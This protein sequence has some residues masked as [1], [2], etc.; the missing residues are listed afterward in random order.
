MEYID[1]YKLKV[2]KLQ[3]DINNNIFFNV[4]SLGPGNCHFD[5]V[6][7]ISF[8]MSTKQSWKSEPAAG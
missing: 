3:T 6:Q 7:D 2:G 4:F 5:F 8:L 1:K